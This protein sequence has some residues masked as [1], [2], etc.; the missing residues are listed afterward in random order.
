MLMSV[1]W[2]IARHAMMTPRRPAAVDDRR[3]Y[4]YAQLFGGAMFL[5]DQI[6]NAT[7]LPHVGILLPTSGAFPMALLGTWLARRVAVPLNY[8]LSAQE[9][10]YVIQDS[11]IDTIL[12]VG[13]M[14]DFLSSTA[15]AFSLPAGV[16]CVHV[17]QLD[18]TGVPPLRWPPRHQRDDLAVILYTSGTSG[19]PKGVMLTHGNL[20]SNVD[21]AIRHAG[22][23]QADT[24][25]GV[26]PQFHSFG[27]TALTL[28]PL[29]L[30]AKAVY[31]ARFVPKKVVG[32]IRKHRPDIVT[33]IPSMYGALLS[34]KD[35]TAADFT[36]IRLAVSGGEPLPRAVSQQVLQR[37][38]LHLREGYGL[39]E[40]APMTNWCTPDHH[41]PHSVGKTLPGV[42]V[43]VVDEHDQPLAPGREGQVIV[44]GPNVM[45]GYYKL[46]QQTQD[47]F[48]D[49]NP[50]RHN[51]ALTAR[52]WSSAHRGQ[53]F[54]RTGDIG[55]LDEEGYLYIT[56]RLKEMMIIG[57][58]NVFP[59]EIEEVLNQYPSVEDSAV[60]GKSD[61]LRG[62]RPVAFVAMRNGEAFDETALRSWCRDRLAGYKVPREIRQV[63]A[64]PRGPTGKIL[65]RN[66]PTDP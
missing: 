55:H 52:P 41:K 62:E 16:K 48:V 32:L 18:F 39:T 13:P 26:L 63:D 10:A 7:A 61:G 24:F 37:F 44:S 31:S 65:R 28:L 45:K 20:R 66:L 36:S 9:L 33:A 2:P 46:P 11:D 50:H 4:T 17:D 58:E 60:A 29:R 59:R 23:T 57:G 43:L 49:L 5:A 22:L 64:V 53:R 54:F 42:C 21:A 14:L 35:A 34:V 12:T 1:L 25:L 19:R 8:L 30:G 51:T 56:G 40:T 47:V 27:L 3:S 15:D 38:G 6:E